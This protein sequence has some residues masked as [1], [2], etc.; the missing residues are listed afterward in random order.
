MEL[1]DPLLSAVDVKDLLGTEDKLAE[2]KSALG[3]LT[4]NGVL[5]VSTST[6][7][8]FDEEDVE[9]YRHKDTHV[10][11]LR[12]IAQEEELDEGHRRNSVHV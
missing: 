9:L 8:P 11:R 3:E 6:Q 2:Y 4:G 5:E 12:L 1:P 10:E 7:R